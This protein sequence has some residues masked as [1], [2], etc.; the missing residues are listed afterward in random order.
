MLHLLTRLLLELGDETLHHVSDLGHGIRAE[1]SGDGGQHPAVELHRL[2][3]QI[4]RRPPLGL[5]VRGGGGVAPPGHQ[6][7]AALLEAQ[8]PLGGPH[9]LRGQQL[10]GLGDGHG[11]PV[12][13]LHALLI[14]LGLLLAGDLHLLEVLLQLLH[15]ALRV[16]EL[17]LLGPGGLLRLGLALTLRGLVAFPLGDHQGEL[18][19][20]LLVR[21]AQ[22]QLLLLRRRPLLPELVLQRS[23]H[24]LDPRGREVQGIQ[25]LLR[26]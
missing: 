4:L 23:Q 8:P 22:L 11:L 9:L 19:Q 2:A 20:Q 25:A 13:E 16:R 17:G 5:V 3:L 12:P 24:L 15:G 10:R 1:A 18:L 21:V 6:R 7:G 26:L 14:V